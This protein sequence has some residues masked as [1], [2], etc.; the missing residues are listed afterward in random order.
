MKA[1]LACF[2][3]AVVAL[4]GTP[5]QKQSREVKTDTVTLKYLGAQAGR[6]LMELHLF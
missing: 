4:L 1:E 2:A 3:F 5:A 6:F